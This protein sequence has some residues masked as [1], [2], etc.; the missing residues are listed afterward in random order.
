M[1]N[2]PAVVLFAAILASVIGAQP[3]TPVIGIYTQ[4]APNIKGYMYTYIAASYVK[5]LEMSGA[6][7]IPL[8]SNATRA[9]LNSTLHKI[10]GVLFPGGDSA[11]DIKNSW[12]KTA[13]FIL[14]FAKQQN[15]QGK[16]FP[17]WGTCLGH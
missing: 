1:V 2:T 6:Q 11:I 7:V 3:Q 10:N 4:H 17:V 14:Q 12:T 13:D 16:V 9:E 5:Y 15:D 8:F